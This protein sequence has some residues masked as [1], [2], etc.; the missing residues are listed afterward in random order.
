[1]IGFYSG[2]QK[3]MNISKMIEIY[4]W[5]YTEFKIEN[6]FTYMN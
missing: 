1:M 6:K 2:K 5:F 3:S 4:I